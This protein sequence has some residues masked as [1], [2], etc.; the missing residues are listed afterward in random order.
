MHISG[1]K[2]F[3]NFIKQAHIGTDPTG[4][5]DS[6]AFGSFAN[7]GDG[8]HIDGDAH[9][10]LIDGTG[11]GVDFFSVQHLPSIEHG[12]NGAVDLAKLRAGFDVADSGVVISNNGGNGVV[13]DGA[14]WNQVG[15]GTYIGTNLGGT[16]ALGNTGDGISITGGATLNQVGPRGARI[17]QQITYD[18]NDDIVPGAIWFDVIVPLIVS[19]NLGAGIMIEGNG[20][21]DNSIKGALIGAGYDEE[22]L[23]GLGN[24]GPGVLI[25]DG[26]TENLVDEIEL[27]V[28]HEPVSP[29][30]PP[31]V[32]A[33]KLKNIIVANGTIEAPRA[34]IEITG[35]G[36]SDNQV[37][38]S[39]IGANPNDLTQTNLGNTGDGVLVTASASEN[40]IGDEGAGNTI[41]KNTGRGVAIVGKN[42]VIEG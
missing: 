39:H 21:D 12:G 1:D 17:E 14:H 42:Q 23:I 3:L 2:S 29:E 34:G 25:R 9:H 5:S 32:E 10:N 36:T 13:I 19:G 18:E 15:G 27:V 20:T 22:D 4:T 24:D 11:I 6:N 8:A 41:A 7:T 16:A 30:D 31:D 38:N 28:I 33:V 26:A 40:L 35:A 37:Y